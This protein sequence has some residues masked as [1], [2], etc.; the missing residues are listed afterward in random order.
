MSQDP[1]LQQF[2]QVIIYKFFISDY[3]NESFRLKVHAVRIYSIYTYLSWPP[4]IV[5]MLTTEH[6]TAI[7]K[8]S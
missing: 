5:D 1:I 8:P 4:V 3:W 2:I 6:D 7:S